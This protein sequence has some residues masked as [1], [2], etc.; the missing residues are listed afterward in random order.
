MIAQSQIPSQ[1]RKVGNCYEFDYEQNHFDLIFMLG[2]TT[3]I[4]ETELAKNLAF[5]SE[6]MA[7]NSRA[8]ITFTNRKSLDNSLRTAAKSIVKIFASKERIVAQDFSFY[9]YA[10]PEVERLLGSDFEIEKTVFLNHTIFPFS[11]LLPSFSVKMAKWIS[12]S[13]RN[14]KLLNWLRSDIMFIMKKKEH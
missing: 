3:Y 11:R 12:K 10:L 6:K 13:F 9:W 7:T 5:I 1:N 4:N 2:V 14:K 8:I